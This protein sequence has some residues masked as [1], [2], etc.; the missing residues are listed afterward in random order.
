MTRA[1]VLITGRDPSE[2]KGGG[3]SYVRAHARAALRAGFEPHIFCV[4]ERDDEVTHD[5]GVVHRVAS[6]FLPRGVP[7]AVPGKQRGRFLA[8]WLAT[9][10][11][12]PYTVMLHAP[13]LAAGIE[14]F[15]GKRTDT[16]LMHGFYTW[17]CVG[18]MAQQRLRR[19]GIETIVVNSFYTTATTETCAKAR[20]AAASGSLFQRAVFQAER[21][22]VRH[23]VSRHERG[24]YTRSQLVLLNYESVRGL[25]L[26][27]HGRGADT[28]KLPYAS[29]AAFLRDGNNETPEPEP[30]NEPMIVSVSRHDPRK[31]L[32]VLI[33]ALAQL[34]ASGARFRACLLSGGPLFAEHQRLVTQLGLADVV[35]LTGWVQDSY[36]RLLCADVFVLPSLQEGSGSVSLLEALQAGVA[37]VASNI[38]GIPE[39]VTNGDNALLVEPGNVDQLR[40]ALLRVITDV[41]L[42]KRLARRAR[43]TFTEK[44]SAD[45]F[46][47]E[48][49]N[50]YVEMHEQ[51][52][53]LPQREAS[54]MKQP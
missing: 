7:P 45:A 52:P 10:A 13:W 33:R 11:V 14:K 49:R 6:P 38:D 16:R 31:G 25:L 26:A 30:R 24:A 40:D 20:G 3:S 21:L 44:F 4:G 37:I 54:A 34:R 8:H 51:T 12:T 47:N 19:R 35:A 15:I 36:A 9:F 29:E 23:A 2:G 39:D 42:R 1:V 41:E 28:R 48:L 17:G 43:E 53:R 5:F 50:L 32:H 46:V 22:W 27:E 18:L